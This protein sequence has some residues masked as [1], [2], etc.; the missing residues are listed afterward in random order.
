MMIFKFYLK[1]VIINNGIDKKF[2]QYIFDTVHFSKQIE[3]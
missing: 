1:Q 3:L 2:L